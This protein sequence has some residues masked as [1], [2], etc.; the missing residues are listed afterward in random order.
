MRD[1]PITAAVLGVIQ[2]K[3]TDIA[4]A[5][6][7]LEIEIQVS[8]S[9]KRERMPIRIHTYTL[10]PK[11]SINYQMWTFFLTIGTVRF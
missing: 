7:G 8:E 11:I 10:C 1:R 5:Q 6:V 3:N 4:T 9:W 2:R